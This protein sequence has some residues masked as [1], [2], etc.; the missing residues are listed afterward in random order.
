M[1][2]VLHELNHRLAINLF[3]ITICNSLEY[4]D[5][6]IIIIAFFI[7]YYNFCHF[8]NYIVYR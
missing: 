6:V 2:G 7:K 8:G 3:V 1:Q 4:Y 5:F